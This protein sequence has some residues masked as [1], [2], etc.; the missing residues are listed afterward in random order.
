ME[1]NMS[2]GVIFDLDGT[3]LDTLTSILYHVNATLAAYRLEPIS[4][5]ECKSF[6]GNGARK[7]ITR[8]F[9]SRGVYDESVVDEA[10]A[11]YNAAY[12]ADP[13]VGTSPFD[14]IEALLHGLCRHGVSIAVV[15]NKPQPTVERLLAHFFPDVPFAVRIG[16]RADLPL[17]PHPDLGTYVL[18]RLALSPTEVT[19]VGDSD[20]DISF[21]HAI[22]TRGI[23][24]S[25]GFRSRECLAG[26]GADAIVDTADALLAL[27][28]TDCPTDI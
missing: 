5:E 27:L 4:M 22:G 25:W 7:L 26:A 2:F 8:A 21:A 11:R 19:M 17:K 20:V 12:D 15:S 18:S 16:G 3:L 9:A 28:L 23:G 24:V 10:L 1:E 13:Y 14:G 6:I